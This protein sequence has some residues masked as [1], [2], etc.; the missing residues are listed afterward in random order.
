MKLAA[1][2]TWIATPADSR[3]IFLIFSYDWEAIVRETSEMEYVGFWLRLGATLIDT[4]LLMLITVPMMIAVYGP[5][6]LLHDSWLLGPADVMISY[7][8]PAVIQLAL[9]IFLSTTPGKMA[10]GAIIVDASTGNKPSVG[11][12]IKRCLGYYLS[13]IPLCL[14]FIC[15]GF[16]SRKR[17][18]HDRIAGTVVIKRKAGER[19]NV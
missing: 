18:L 9:W 10:V 2:S 17:G 7:V 19:V 3:N 13:A 11:Q 14:G 15:I 6:Y 5:N 12:F 16:D 8:L 4:I 1:V